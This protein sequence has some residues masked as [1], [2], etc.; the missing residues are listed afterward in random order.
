MSELLIKLLTNAVSFREAVIEDV[1]N[2]NSNQEMP[3][4]KKTELVA[5]FNNYA[6]TLNVIACIYYIRKYRTLEEAFKNSKYKPDDWNWINNLL[7][8]IWDELSSMDSETISETLSKAI[9]SNTEIQEK[10]K[11]I[12]S[13][14]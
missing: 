7:T 13:L 12:S 9:K 2:N 6:H 1:N 11:Q 14:C 8:P 4:N 10:I 3:S 5:L